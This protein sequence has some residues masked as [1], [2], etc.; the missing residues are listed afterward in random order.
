MIPGNCSCVSI[1]PGVSA[2]RGQGS[3]FKVDGQLN[4]KECTEKCLQTKSQIAKIETI[5]GFTYFADTKECYCMTGN[6]TT[7]DS[8]AMT[9]FFN[10]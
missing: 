3:S 10:C 7:I 2:L 4:L 9:C 6:I 8:K 1:T 5:L